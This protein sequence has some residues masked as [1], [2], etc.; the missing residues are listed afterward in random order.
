MASRSPASSAVRGTI[1]VAEVLRAYAREGIGHVQ[2]VLGDRLRT[3]RIAGVVFPGARLRT[4]PFE[5]V[6][7]VAVTSAL[8]LPRG[9]D[10]GAD[11]PCASAFVVL[12]TAIG[13]RAR[14]SGA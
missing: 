7:A 1:D 12:P 11:A 9:N 14:R 3:R 4:A 8:H 10:R 2:L 13:R 5:A 6:D